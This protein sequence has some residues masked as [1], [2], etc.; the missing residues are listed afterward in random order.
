MNQ[1][2]IIEIKTENDVDNLIKLNES[3]LKN[4]SDQERFKADFK[5]GFFKGFFAI[6]NN[7]EDK[8]DSILGYVTF[9]NSYSTWQN[10]VL[11]IND[12]W[13]K[14]ASNIDSMKLVI[15]ALIKKIFSLCQ[16]NDHQRVNI[17]MKLGNQYISLIEEVGGV[18]LTKAEDWLLFEM[19]LDEMKQFLNNKPLTESNFK[20]VKVEN[21]KKYC[22]QIR[23]L[24]REIA[25][26]EKLENQFKISVDGLVRDYNYEK[27]ESF[28]GST[29]LNRFYETMIVIK[30]DWNESTNET[31]ET[32]VGYAVYY[33]NYELER[34]RGCYL[35]DL[36]IQEKYRRTG[37]GT[38]LWRQ[39]I[40]DCLI[41]YNA[42]FM[43]W[44]VLE[45]N[46]PAIDFY[47][48]HNSINLTNS[49]DNLNLFRFV[50]EIIYSI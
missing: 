8:I 12:L 14:N 43:Q 17:N 23:D 41:N 21:M 36:Y 19:R 48:K 4:Q 3:I 25:I 27:H 6:D 49:K 11:Y 35:E 34:G 46:K 44:S 7:F 40:E 26:F 28:D 5:K 47:Y 42:N 38:F 9:Y 15:K 18:N 39:V 29:H 32:V 10:R 33:F 2:N 37:L 31:V 30:E 1:V 22:N 16:E 13:L 24:F 50:T 45:W 20:V